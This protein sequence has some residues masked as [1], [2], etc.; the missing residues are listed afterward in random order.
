MSMSMSA[1]ALIKSGVSLLVA[2]VALIPTWVFLLVK[3]FT[4][5]EGFWQ[6]FVVYGLGVWFLGSLQLIMAIG[7][8]GVICSIII[9]EKF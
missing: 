5:P 9:V 4:Q 1:S 3:H 8:I 7:G 2:L 6:N